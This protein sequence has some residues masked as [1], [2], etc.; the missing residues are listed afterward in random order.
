M[1]LLSFE[2]FTPTA[3]SCCGSSW[4]RTESI[5]EIAAAGTTWDRVIVNTT[6]P[7]AQIGLWLK[8]RD[9]AAEQMTLVTDDERLTDLAEIERVGELIVVPAGEPGVAETIEQTSLATLVSVVAEQITTDE[10]VWMHSRF[11]TRC[12]DAPRDLFP[13]DYFDEHDLTPLDPAESFEEEMREQGSDREPMTA[14]VPPILDDWRPPQIKLSPNDDPD[15]IMTWM[16]TYGCQ[17][18]LIDAVVGLLSE[19]AAEH[20]RGMIALT[21][22]S[23]FSLGQNG[24][25]GHSIGPI[26]SPQLHVPFLCRPFTAEPMMGIGVRNR[27]V[28]ASDSIAAHWNQSSAFQPPITAA[29]WAEN[30]DAA[31]VVTSD[32]GTPV[33]VTEQ[34]WFYVEDANLELPTSA[35]EKL[36]LKPDDASDI[37]D[38]VRLRPDVAERLSETMAGRSP[39]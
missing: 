33:A 7:V 25:I 17:V 28:T 22:T 32:A 37:N 2:G 15:W 3:L 26:R 23:G 11:L 13:I 30:R 35:P 8:Q 21:G 24:T 34:D 12:W 20:D 31:P 9:F 27:R 1:L 6:D 5:D 39:K 19:I 18:R 4:N 36:F 16:R 10:N 38:V 14:M 29:H